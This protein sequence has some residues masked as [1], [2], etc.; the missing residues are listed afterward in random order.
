MAAIPKPARPSADGARPAGSPDENECPSSITLP[1]DSQAAASPV[2]PGKRGRPSECE[3]FQ[4]L[5]LEKL[6]QD[7]SAQRIFQDLVSDHGFTAGYDSVKR[8]VRQLGHSRELPMRRMECAAGEEAQVDF[9][10]GA[11]RTGNAA[12]PTSFASC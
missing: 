11:V 3:A 10:T 5:I 4:A 7:L 6:Q 8:F 2:S 9:G 12:R 1:A